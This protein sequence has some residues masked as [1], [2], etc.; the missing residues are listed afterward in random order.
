MRL[1]Y[2]AILLL[3][4]FVSK[5]QQ[6]FYITGQT[7]DDKGNPLANVRIILASSGYEYRSGTEGYFGFMANMESDSLFATLNGYEPVKKQISAKEPVLII[8]KRDEAQINRSRRRLSSLTKNLKPF[9][10]YSYWQNTETYSSTIENMFVDAQR[11]PSTEVS[12]NYNRASY[13]NIRRFLSMNDMVPPDAVRI[14]EM[15][16]YFDWKYEAPDPDHVFKMRSQVTSCPW[17]KEHQLLFLNVYSKKLNLDSLPPSHLIF[18]IDISGSMDLPNRLPLLKSAFKVLTN[19]LRSKD[20]VSIVVYGGGTRVVL[21][22][23][24][25][26]EKMKINNAID[27]LQAGGSTPGGSG[28]KMAYRIARLHFIRGGNNRVILA[29]DGDFNVGIKTEDE[30]EKLIVQEKDAG[31]YLT[32]LGVGMGNYKDSKIQILAQK[33]NGNFSYLDSYAE[34]E[35]VLFR[36]FF[37]T[38]YTVA[39]DVSL[40][41][42]F[43]T[44]YVQQYRLIG[45]DNKASA[46]RDTTAL[47]D[48]GDIGSGNALMVAF[49]ITPPVKP[50]SVGQN[51]ATASV[52]YTPTKKTMQEQFDY[53]V[54]NNYIDLSQTSSE[55]N[56]AAS[57]IMFGMK[58]KRSPYAKSLKW[59]FVL[60]SA[61]S[62]THNQTFTE[63]EF[64][65]LIEEAKTVYNR[66]RKFRFF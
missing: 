45:F 1:L 4:G 2:L 53:C 49:E 37:Q 22:A 19:N 63:K 40:Y 48:G 35:K 18:L 9:A 50:H 54:S 31:I 65:H 26:N 55:Y 21:N 15:L 64:I 24:P 11:Y 28:I 32:C 5:A 6:Q 59:D 38:L 27:S 3:S 43:N 8:L 44:D 42:H 20:T 13:S 39:D 33:G 23:M 57:V 51:Y 12:L 58:L 46:V 56:L 34:A 47:V 66:R 29:T 30:L 62:A 14:D 25:G 61:K 41:I 16:N 36:E 7:R 17:N 10:Q 60:T 52:L